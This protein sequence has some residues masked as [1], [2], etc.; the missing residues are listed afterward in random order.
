MLHTT[1]IMV[2]FVRLFAYFGQN[3]VAM[4][5]PLRPLQ[6]EISSFDWLTTQTPFYK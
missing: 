5:T 4:A 6:L 3:L 1:E 2:V